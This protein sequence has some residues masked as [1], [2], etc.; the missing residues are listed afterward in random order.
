[1]ISV[2]SYACTVDSSKKKHT[3]M[4][5]GDVDLGTRMILNLKKASW[6]QETRSKDAVTVSELQFSH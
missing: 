3:V 1:M 6:K 2:C 5:K 4:W